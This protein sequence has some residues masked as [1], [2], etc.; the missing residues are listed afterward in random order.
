MAAWGILAVRFPV[1]R[2]VAVPALRFEW[3]DA[4]RQHPGQTNYLATAALNLDFT[5]HVRLLLDLSRDQLR[6]GTYLSASPPGVFS[7]SA[8]FFVSQVQLRI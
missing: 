7:R 6:A 1:S 8:T 5:A 2:I 3:L 4:D